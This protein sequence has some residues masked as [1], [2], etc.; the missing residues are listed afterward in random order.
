MDLYRILYQ[1]G[2]KYIVSTLEY[3]P[4]DPKDLDATEYVRALT[5]GVSYTYA[6][7]I[8]APDGEYAVIEFPDLGDRFDFFFAEGGENYVRHVWNDGYEELYKAD[9]DDPALKASEIV[10]RWYRAIAEHTGGTHDQE[11]FISKEIHNI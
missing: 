5:E 6:G 4:L 2:I 3:G 7:D 11:L 8:E 1:P 9:F 10:Y